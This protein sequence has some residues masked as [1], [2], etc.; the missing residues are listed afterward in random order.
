[1]VP[2]ATTTPTPTPQPPPPPTPPSSGVSFHMNDHHHHHNETITKTI[3]LD[4]GKSVTST[5][6]SPSPPPPPPSTTSTTTS[7]A[8][9][10][11][12]CFHSVTG[13]PNSDRKITNA[14]DCLQ[15][16]VNGT[17]LIKVKASMRHYRRFYTLEEDLSMIRWV[18]STK[19]TSKARLPVKSIKEVR[20][21]KSTEVLKNPDIAGMYSEDCTFSIMYGDEYESIDLIAL[22]PGEAN[23]WVSGLNFVI[24]LLKSPDSIEGREKMREKW[25]ESLFETES[26]G[27]GLLDEIGT[28]ALMRRINDRLCTKSL[29]QKITEFELSKKNGDQRGCISKHA[30][31]SLFTQTATRPDIYFILVR[32][33]GRDYM[34]AEEF[35]L[36]LEGEQGVN[37]T[38]LAHCREIIEKFEPSAEARIRKQFLIDGFT[39]F[40]LSEACDIGGSDSVYQNMDKE[41]A[42]Y[43]IATSNNTYLLEDQVKGPSSTEGYI[44]ALQSGCRCIKI[45]T[46]DSAEGIPIVYH[47]NTLTS[48]IPLNDVLVA[49]RD[50]AFI[51]SSYPV[52][53]HLENHCSIM[54]QRSMV[55]MFREIFGEML[56]VPD[57]P[58]AESSSTL[59]MTKS[60]TPSISSNSSNE[61]HIDLANCSNEPNGK[62]RTK[63]VTSSSNNKTEDRRQ[64]SR[65]RRSA[66]PVQDTQLQQLWSQLTPHKLQNK[67]I[68]MSK[69][70]SK[71]DLS[72]EEIGDDDEDDDELQ[73]DSTRDR[74]S[75]KKVMVL[76]KELSNLV[77]LV[78]ND[79]CLESSNKSSLHNTNSY[80]TVSLTETSANKLAMTN[81]WDDLV[82]RNKRFL[83]QV[84]PDVSRIDSS[85]LNPLDFWNSGV[86]FISMNYQT[87]GQ[88]M[89]LYRGWFIQNGSCGYVL[90]PK[91]LR[92]KYSTFNARRKDVMP[93]IDPLNIRIKVISGQQLPRP[94]G[95]SLKASSIDPYVMVQCLGV[96]MDCAEARTR[97]VSSD[98]HNPI[99]DESF[100]FVVNVPEL[101]LIRFLVLDDDFINDDFI[102]QLT[103]PVNQLQPGFKHVRLQNMN[104]E[105]VDG[106]LFVKISITHRY[107]SKQKLR[108]K[109]S[110]S[111]KNI[112]EPK[113]VGIKSIDEQLKNAFTI[114][115]EVVQMRKNVE[116]HILELCDECS[117][118]ESAN[119]A[120]CLRIIT[121]RLASCATIVKFSIKKS[122]LGYSQIK[123]TGELTPK[124]ARTIATLDKTLA[125][126]HH[127]CKHAPNIINTLTELYKQFG[128]INF[129]N[130]LNFKE[131]TNRLTSLLDN[132]R[133][134]SPKG[135]KEP[136][137]QQQQQQMEIIQNDDDISSNS[138]SGKDVEINN[139]NQNGATHNKLS[140]KFS[141]NQGSNVSGG[142]SST[143]DKSST[144]SSSTHESNS[145]T[146]S[147]IG[148]IKS[149]NRKGEK[150]Y[151]NLFWNL[152]IIKT[153]LEI[154]HTIRN[155]CRN[156][157]EQID[158]IAE[159]LEHIFERE[160][161]LNLRSNSTIIRELSNMSLMSSQQHYIN[162][163]SNCNLNDLDHKMGSMT[164]VGNNELQLRGILKKSSSPT[165]IAS[166]N[167][168]QEST[169]PNY[170]QYGNK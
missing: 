56:F 94:K 147:P 134:T 54:V 87:N 80:E 92:E 149:T 5:S 155:D 132:I 143:A 93:G 136:Q 64:S 73:T 61:E 36:F 29:K 3:C 101:A 83:T 91:F 65:R 25:L 129:D 60:K 72:N 38:S 97:T 161:I 152:N 86:Q 28:I 67:I 126:F 70:L 133:S 89:D 39:Q 7:S 146:N 111:Y 34:T 169:N 164:P 102:G 166:R 23:I 66:T 77:S 16:M 44:R 2:V 24:G 1:M 10:K 139:Q 32:Y 74:T 18:P 40:I 57:L 75:V 46:H 4:H 150:V 96:T 112:Y 160:H 63:S 157:F 20:P 84:T 108:R 124:L 140:S 78:W 90:K 168:Q 51:S 85:N 27:K 123:V 165:P 115:H 79:F 121:L 12:V 151:E 71:N 19:K 47:A 156:A 22:T 131:H 8:S 142:T 107:G 170:Q 43:Y 148:S 50:N 153:E 135:I 68:I 138:S 117:L 114:V 42:H 128:K 30:F 106:N 13:Q 15:F 21:G 167:Q 49:I 119:M 130:Q 48:K 105:V 14:L 122:D 116:K 125:E 159:S 127:I 144:K 99:F 6:L 82:Q 95:A 69:K 145:S 100:E 26:E 33:C 62:V 88:I 120:Q 109:R 9:H 55:N 41:F 163:N 98:G 81:A 17:T 76:C 37:G 58:E 110:W 162:T 118:Q 104:G 141:F 103:I 113:Q 137:Q 59:V 31:I 52:I 11:T 35:Q 45:D 154:L 53:I 158:R